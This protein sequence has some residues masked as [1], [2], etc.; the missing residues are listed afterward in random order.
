MLDYSSDDL[1]T[2]INNFNDTIDNVTSGSITYSIRDCS[3]EGV[4]V[5]KGQ[6]ISIVDG[7]LVASSNDKISALKDLLKKVKVIILGD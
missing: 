6:Y 3:I 1:A 4:D 7:K 5:K 2:I